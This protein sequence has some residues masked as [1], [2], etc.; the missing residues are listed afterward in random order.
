VRRCPKL[1]F[2]GSRHGSVPVESNEAPWN[3]S[4]L[5][6]FFK[7]EGLS[8]FLAFLCWPHPQRIRPTA[9]V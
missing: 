8:F 2:F 6:L 3:K 7:K 9:F 1:F 5:L 4:F